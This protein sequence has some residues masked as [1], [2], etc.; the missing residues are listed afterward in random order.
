MTQEEKTDA[1][2]NCQPIGNI[3]GTVEKADLP[4]VFQSA[5]SAVFMDERCTLKIERV[6]CNKKFPF[7]A[8]RTFIK[9]YTV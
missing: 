6:F 5:N 4:Q 2:T 1:E 7:V 9:K 8:T 3:H